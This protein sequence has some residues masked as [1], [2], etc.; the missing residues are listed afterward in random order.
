ME[1]KHLSHSTARSRHAKSLGL[2]AEAK[3]EE[4]FCELLRSV[5][6]LQSA[7]NKPLHTHRLLNA[8]IKTAISDLE[9]DFLRGS[10]SKC[11]EQLRLYCDFIL[12]TRGYWLPAP[13]RAVQL[14]GDKEVV[15][16]GGIPSSAFPPNFRSKLLH[17]GPMR[18]AKVSVIKDLP[19]IQTLSLAEWSQI[20]DFSLLEWAAAVRATQVHNV[21]FSELEDFAYYLPQMDRAERFQFKRWKGSVKGFNGRCLGKH[22]RKFGGSEYHIVEVRSEQVVGYSSAL[23]YRFGRRLMYAEDLSANRPIVAK[24]ERSIDGVQLTLT[25]RI[26]F[27]E[28]KIFRAIGELNSPQNEYPIVWTFPSEQEKPVTSSLHNLGIKI[29]T[30]GT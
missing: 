5:L 13:L 20:P 18:R 8:A 27:E 3:D 7:G 22:S 10:F 11:L 15:L 24:M 4:Y 2:H 30:T 23:P 6:W 26:P 14:P 25:S 29:D 17:S 9:P 12:F 1:L 19:V 16:V 28:G 21:H